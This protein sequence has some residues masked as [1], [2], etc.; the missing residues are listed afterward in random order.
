MQVWEGVILAMQQ[1]RSEKLKSFF[2]LIGVILGVMF[3]IVVVTIIE[4]LDRYVREEVTSQ[5]FGVSTVTLRRWPEVDINSDE[6]RWRRRMRAP[7]LRY[8]DAEAI[9]AR[10]TIPAR[11]ASASSY[12]SR[13]ARILRRHRSS[14]LLISTSGQRRSVTVLTPKTCEVTSSRT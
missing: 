13:G 1:L 12:R 6:E 14:S 9:R 2:S 3:L 7:R 10:L 4:G 5:V 8:E 11:I